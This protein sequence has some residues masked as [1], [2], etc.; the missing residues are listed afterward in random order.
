MCEAAISKVYVDD[1]DTLKIIRALD[2]NIVHGHGS[3]STL[4]IKS[5]DSSFVKLLSIIFHN[6]LNS[7]IFP[8]N[9]KRS[10]IDLPAKKE[11]SN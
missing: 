7:G 9:W 10:I 11:T 4:M 8:D 3:I 6:S 5:C 1:Q 2:V